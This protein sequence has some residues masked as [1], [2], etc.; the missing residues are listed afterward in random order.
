MGLYDDNSGTSSVAFAERQFEGVR[1]RKEDE[2]K[3]AEKFSKK[4]ALTNFVV[5][6]A[7]ALL[8]SRADSLERSQ[9]PKRAA[10]NATI[11][12]STHW[13]GV[14]TQIIESGKSREQYL[15]DKFYNTLLS[16]AQRSQPNVN[17]SGFQ[18]A[19]L[20]RAK[21][22]ASDHLDNFNSLLDTAKVIPQWDNFDEF[23]KSHNT[24]PRNIGS[25]VT[26]KVSNL[27][28]SETPETLK[29]AEEELITD[30]NR[31]LDGLFGTEMGEQLSQFQNNVKA[32]RA[33]SKDSSLLLAEL[34]DEVKA[35]KLKG[36]LI[37]DPQI[38]TS[39]WI[40]VA[41]GD[42]QQRTITT[43]IN[44]L[45][46]T[47]GQPVESI[48]ER[49]ETQDYFRETATVSHQNLISFIETL[50]PKGQMFVLDRVENAEKFDDQII[51]SDFYNI[52]KDV[53]RFNNNAEYG[54]LIKRDLD[55]EDRERESIFNATRI[56]QQVLLDGQD[57]AMKDT[58]GTLIIQPDP[59]SKRTAMAA[60][61]TF[62]QLYNEEWKEFYSNSNNTPTD[63]HQLTEFI[64]KN[65]AS[66]LIGALGSD[67]S[68][69][70]FASITDAFKEAVPDQGSLE[71]LERSQEGEA[72][73]EQFIKLNAEGQAF[74][75]QDLARLFNVKI[76]EVEFSDNLTFNLFKDLSSGEYYTTRSDTK[77]AIPTESEDRS[78]DTSGELALESRKIEGRGM[79]RT[80]EWQAP[81]IDVLETAI[82]DVDF[83]SLN[84]GEL[85]TL[86]SM[87]D[88]K[89][90][91]NL[92][93][94]ENIRL[95][96]PS[97]DISTNLPLSTNLLFKTKVQNSLDAQGIL[98]GSTRRTTVS[99]EFWDSLNTLLI[100]G[101]RTYLQED[102]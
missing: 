81:P 38:I 98:L 83:S 35:G 78:L 5:Q 7:N 94:G 97:M 20:H 17:I 42:T 49:I 80:L 52:M 51:E 30:Q 41:N 58:D 32:F 64:E 72:L 93:L 68:D 29:D 43:I 45:D 3:K 40:R 67:Q 2:V 65:D 34:A 22:Q 14:N 4:L 12:N 84:V 39:D 15:V 85:Q 36:K 26:G 23:Y 69:S 57:F 27:F 82:Q 92:G 74:T 46:P 21:E 59:N 37:G 8:N 9:A 53:T 11:Q 33:T 25:W 76:E 31:K 95:R 10:Y 86:A 61:V 18:S 28:K 1:Q 79:Q 56:R 48:S 6:G 24:M 66:N 75:Q 88:G 60:G 99:Q 13:R 16:D 91:E 90:A 73:F 19:I 54:R 62:N 102:E 50:T 71:A 101:S 96:S 44:S 55:R 89:I 47:T 100:E 70:N 87:S 63:S 77:L